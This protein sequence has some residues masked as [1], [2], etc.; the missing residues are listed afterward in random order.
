MNP[1]DWLTLD[2]LILLVANNSHCMEEPEPFV[3]LQQFGASSVDL[4]LSFRLRREDV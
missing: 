2:N 4:Q 1:L 3:F